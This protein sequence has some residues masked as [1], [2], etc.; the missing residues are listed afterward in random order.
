MQIVLF[1]LFYSILFIY[2]LLCLIVVPI[3]NNFI[4]SL[5]FRW[6]VYDRSACF[7]PTTPRNA[8]MT[9]IEMPSAAMSPGE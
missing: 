4:A 2:F 5:N 3:W 9:A 1:L 8:P 7:M 6:K